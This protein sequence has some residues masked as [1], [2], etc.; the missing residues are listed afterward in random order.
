MDINDIELN[1]VYYGDAL[2]V[3]KTFPDNVADCLI[4]S[5][6][7]Y[8]L[9]D[10]GHKNQI[11]IEPSKEI[12][13]NK[14]C[15]IFDEVKRVL[16]KEG[17]CFVNLGDS[18]DKNNCLMNVPND[19]A[20]EMIK[21]NWFLR[22]EII[23]NKPNC[24][25]ESVKN[26]FTVSHEKIFFFTQIKTKYYFKQQFEKQATF[27]TKKPYKNSKHKNL[28]NT[29]TSGG[30]FQKYGI[31]PNPEGRNKRTVWDIK[32]KSYNEAHFAVYP[33]ELIKTPIL[34][35]CPPKGV[36]LDCF[37]GSGTTAEAALLADCYFLGVELNK[38]YEKHIIKRITPLLQQNK[39]I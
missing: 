19:F 20:S 17:T 1:K 14:L 32:V 36:I 21:R 23:W 35:G 26:R 30:G 12:Y 2:E 37:M 15:D 8:N 6:P 25:P 27:V 24:T 13:I 16:K 18:Y 9:R 34:S 31:K 7:Y 3:L 4:T 29:A 28:K 5:P 10:Y 39:L 11:G 33:I 38:E 22:N